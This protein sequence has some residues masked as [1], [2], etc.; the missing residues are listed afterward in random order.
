VQE[1]HR[2]EIDK[3]AA[4]LSGEKPGSHRY[5]ACY[6]TAVSAIEKQLTDEVLIKYKADAQKWS[7]EK[8]PPLVQRRYVHSKRFGI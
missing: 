3:L 7:D 6:S 5:I 2:E 4:E 1:N 8:P